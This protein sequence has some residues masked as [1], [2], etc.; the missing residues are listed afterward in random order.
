[1]ASRT[2]K[3]VIGKALLF[4]LWAAG[5]CA[6]GLLPPVKHSYLMPNSTINGVASGNLSFSSLSQQKQMSPQLK[7]ANAVHSPLSSPSPIEYWCFDTLDL[8]YMEC[9]GLG[10]PGDD[11]K[12]AAAVCFDQVECQDGCELELAQGVAAESRTTSFSW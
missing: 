5:L 3:F 4:G 10:D 7:V 12:H 2:T 11:C 8:S 6:G 1:M 9:C